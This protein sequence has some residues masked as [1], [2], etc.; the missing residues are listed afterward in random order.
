MC[1][2]GWGVLYQEAQTN[3]RVSN[4][5]KAALCF[6]VQMLPVFVRGRD[7]LCGGCW[8]LQEKVDLIRINV[9]SCKLVKPS[10]VDKTLQTQM[11]RSNP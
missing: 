5:E 4:F 9:M 2:G 6:D 11:F 1:Q 7:K 3:T 10:G 8:I